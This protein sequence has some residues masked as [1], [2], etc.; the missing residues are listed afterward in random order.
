[1]GKTRAKT[2]NDG[3]WRLSHVMMISDI[4]GL[5]EKPQYGHLVASQPGFARMAKYQSAG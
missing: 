5:V 1:M 4:E 2:E 3:G